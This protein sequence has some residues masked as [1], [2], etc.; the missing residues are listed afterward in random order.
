M[1][2]SGALKKSEKQNQRDGKQFDRQRS[3]KEHLREGLHLI[4]AD[5][6]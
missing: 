5:V 3:A 6:P 4:F 1:P 2:S